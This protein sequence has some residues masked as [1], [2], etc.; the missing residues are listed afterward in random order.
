MKKRLLFSALPLLGL[1]LSS[2]VW[3][4]ADAQLDLTI[5]TILGA[6]VKRPYVAVWLENAAS[7]QF[8]GNVAVWYDMSRPNNIGAT[9]VAARSSKLVEGERQ[10]GFVPDRWRIRCDT[11]SRV[12]DDQ[13]GCIRGSEEVGAG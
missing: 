7:H 10:S 6:R 8:A 11:A 1:G 9:Q 4:A 12:A 5:P 13:S 2:P 3:A